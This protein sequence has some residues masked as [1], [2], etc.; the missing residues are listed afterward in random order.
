VIYQDV[1]DSQ[2]ELEQLSPNVLVMNYFLSDFRKH[3]ENSLLAVRTLLEK[4]YSE[5]VENM[6]TPCIIVLNDM[7]HNQAR[8]CFECF[9]EIISKHRSI[10]IKKFRF[11]NPTKVLPQYTTGYNNRGSGAFQIPKR[12]MGDFE[13]KFSPWK[14][15]S[16]AQYIIEMR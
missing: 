12:F 7:N 2:N 5:V 11:T 10:N 16:S 3:N 13:S 6:A 4:L 8:D 9:S 1:F 14:Y 15:C